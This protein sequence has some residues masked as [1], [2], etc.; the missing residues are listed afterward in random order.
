MAR[1]A[2]ILAGAMAAMSFSGASAQSWGVGVGVEFG[3]P[4]Y[5]PPPAYLYGQPP[6]V[7]A[8]APPPVLYAPAPPVYYQPAAPVLH[9]SVSPD[10]IFDLLENSGY[11]DFGPMAFRDGVYQLQ[12]INPNG[13]LVA[14][15]VSAL[16]GAVENEYPLAAEAAAPRL[17]RVPHAAAVAPAAGPPPGRQLAP[18]P[19][20]HDPLVV[21]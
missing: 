18:P 6:V 20:G 2:L 17:P 7:Y 10:Q 12:A 19:A 9:S 14:L 11:S 4:H 21:Y 15:E 8:P 3:G 1:T 16:D 5:G 13:E